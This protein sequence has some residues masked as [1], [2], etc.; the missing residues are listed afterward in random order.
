MDVGVQD[1]SGAVMAQHAKPGG[2]LTVWPGMACKQT[3]PRRADAGWVIDGVFL[4]GYDIFEHNSDTSG[5][6]CDIEERRERG[7]IR[8]AGGG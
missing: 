4:V 8:S 2:A 5:W 1:E 7:G 6:Y 3:M